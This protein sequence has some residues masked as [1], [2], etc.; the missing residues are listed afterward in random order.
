MC[1]I[2]QAANEAGD[3]GKPEDLMMAFIEQSNEMITL[4]A[5]CSQDVV[6]S[7]TTTF[8]CMFLIEHSL[9]PA[10]SSIITISNK[11]GRIQN[12]DFTDTI[13]FY[14]IRFNYTHSENTF[15][16][17]SECDANDLEKIVFENLNPKSIRQ[18]L[19][20]H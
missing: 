12:H 14:T 19:S 17:I 1:Y 11:D 18:F 3:T 16:L 15:N 2:L 6:T 20:C 9:V 7:R 13:K 8:D 5:N 4:I 10:V